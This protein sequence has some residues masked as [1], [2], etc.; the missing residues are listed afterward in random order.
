MRLSTLVLAIGVALSTPALAETN[1]QTKEAKVAGEVKQDKQGQNPFFTASQLPFQAPRFDVISESDYAPA[2]AAGI[3]QKLTEVE[4]IANNPAEPTFDNTFVAL[5]KSGALLTRTMNVFGAMTSANTSDALQ[6]LDE[7]TSPT[8]AA[9]NDAIM[10][11]SKLFARIKAIYDRRDSLNLDT[12]SLRLVEV[13][14]KNYVLAGANLS[15][16]DKTQLKALNQEAATLS[17]QFTNKLLAASKN[18]ALAIG[19]K[20]L[21]VGLSEGEL[22]AAAQAASERKLDKQWLLVLQNTTQQPDLQSLQDRDTR[23]KLFEA[24]INRAEKNDSNDTRQTLARL[25]KV[26]AEQAKLLGFPNYAAWKLQNQMAKTPDAALAFMRD[27]V[28][29]ATARAEREAKDIQA[30]IDRQNGGFKLAAWDWQ[31]YAEQVRKE[32]YDLDES[33]IKPYFEMSN[34]LHNGVFYA[35]NLLYGISFKERKDI[36]VYHPDVRVY[37]VFDKDGQSLALFYTDF[38]K[39]DNKG[40]GAWMSNFVEQSKLN[41]TKP[42]IYNVSNFTKPAAGQ[43]ALLSYD[44]VITMFHEFGH[45]LH[46]M[47]ADQQYP[48]LSG[49]NTARDFVE[50]PSQFNEHWVSDPQVF[51]HFAKHYQTGEAMPQVLVDKINKADKFNKGY[52]MTELLAAALLDMHW[53]MLGA[54]QPQQDVDKFEAASLRQDKIDL[55]YVPPRYRSSYFQHIWGNGYAAGYYAYLWTEMLADDAFQWFSDN[56]GLTAE[57]GQRFREQVLSQGNSQDLEKLYVK[58]RGQEPSIE[59][60]LINRGLKDK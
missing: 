36:P 55:S 51:A 17:T 25:A 31:F 26:R 52:A 20:T 12:E 53:H 56:G 48:S 14:Y 19:D 5:E 6:K 2:I 50:F 24:S 18:G 42:V 47:F 41:G 33:Q 4:K 58:W 22:A 45:A 21:L 9:L 23:Q 40:G 39:R 37:E 8:L 34:V 27:I 3:Q 10:L 49:T 35:A 16:A 44:D 59:P 15:D 54:D 29:A 7:E 32:K 43:P 1:T 11:N 38:F 13:T 60:M 30:V 46:G 57:N 28:P